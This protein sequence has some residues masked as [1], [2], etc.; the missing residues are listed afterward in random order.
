MVGAEE[1]G[2]RTSSDRDGR[3][4]ASPFPFSSKIKIWPF[5]VVIVQGQQRNEQKSVM[6]VQS[7]CC[8]H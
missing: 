8:A 2:P 6:H 5:H 4:I 1:R 3:I 7:C